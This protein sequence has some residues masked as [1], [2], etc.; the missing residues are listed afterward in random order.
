M[1]KNK[2]FNI[3]L[4]SCLLVINIDVLTH[5]CYANPAPIPDIFELGGIIYDNNNSLHFLNADVVFD[6]DSTDFPN[7][8]SVSFDGSYTIYNPTNETVNVTIYAPFSFLV[9]A[10]E[11]DWQV[12]VNGTSTEFKLVEGYSLNYNLTSY[13]ESYTISYISFYIIV[14]MTILKENSQIISYNFQKN[15]VDPL[16]DREYSIRYIVGT[17]R[18]WKNNIT[19]KVDLKVQGELPNS[20]TT[21]TEKICNVTSI[22]N[23]KSYCWNWD[24]EPINDDSV[25]ITYRVNLLDFGGIILIT[26]ILG[27][28][29]GG[30]VV[31][32]VFLVK[33]KK[34]SRNL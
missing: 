33:R 24:N 31:L 21:N 25:G 28:G 9:Q 11:S 17:A 18:A 19:E 6:I 1:K 5:E 14:N 16:Q 29:I 30:G 20:Y 13:F 3:L 12:K 26:I 7:N 4:I 10:S 2:F 23:G 27:I 8:I 15:I 32:I 34:K 22:S